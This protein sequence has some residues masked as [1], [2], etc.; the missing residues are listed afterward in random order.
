MNKDIIIK[1]KVIT[2]KK[3]VYI[4]LIFKR[5]KKQKVINLDKNKDYNI[6]FIVD[7]YVILNEWKDNFIKSYKVSL[8]N[9]KLEE[10]KQ[11]LRTPKEPVNILAQTKDQ[12]LVLY[13][14]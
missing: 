9:P 2:Q 12:L 10:L 1:I 4:P 8:K 3:M 6:T 11:Y 5:I 7:D 13:D 14:Q